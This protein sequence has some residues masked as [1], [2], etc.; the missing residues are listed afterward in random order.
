MISDDQASRKAERNVIYPMYEGAYGLIAMHTRQPLLIYPELE[1]RKRRKS[2]QL[3]TCT[4]RTLEKRKYRTLMLC[5]MVAA[6][7]RGPN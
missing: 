4:L 3:E 5:V 7:T 6:L 1:E 2:S